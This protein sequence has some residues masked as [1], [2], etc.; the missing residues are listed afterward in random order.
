MSNS[1]ILKIKQIIECE[2]IYIKKF[3]F[4]KLI[5]QAANQ[6]L[7]YINQK[8]SNQKIL[9]ICGIGNNGQD[10]LLTYE[11]LNNKSRNYIYKIKNFS[12]INFKEL[13]YLVEKTDVIFD[14]IFGT[15][16]NKKITGKLKLLINLINNSEKMVVAID[17]P[18]GI[19]ADTGEIMGNCVRADITLAM[20]FYKP[21][22]F[23]HPGKVF[24][25]DIQKMNLRLENYSGN[26]SQINLVKKTYFKN[27]FPQFELNISKYDKGHVVVVG[28]EMSG[29]SR[30]VAYAARK[31]GCGLSTISV[32][33]KNLKFYNQSDPGTIIKVFNINDLNDKDVLVIGPGL[34]KNFNLS[35]VEKIIKIFNGPII[36]D[37]DA[38]SIFRDNREKF[39]NIIKNKSKI[40]L[41]PHEGE[42]RRVFKSKSKS[43]LDKCSEASELVRNCIL[44]KGNDTV[45]SFTKD[46]IWINSVKD[47]NLATAGT[48]D[49]L[50]G[51]IAGLLAQKMSFKHAIIASI[52][53]HSKISESKNDSVVEDF[54]KKI[55]YTIS[56]LKKK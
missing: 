39:Y 15:G 50:C 24:C 22:Y 42:F 9:F 6:I 30:L 41:T 54:L 37:A 43:K 38:I 26:K 32:D 34:G 36:V 14:C 3:S 1:K 12:E 16:L 10:G 48:G 45:V 49:L 13:K 44:L 21:S 40:I 31:T 51:I 5:N 47:N 20:G 8:F 52:W 46:D 7:K 4:D 18:S 28:G 11:K 2:N 23:L 55:P 33:K 19:N 29:A 53:I 17:I 25:G 56:S 35:R 27:K